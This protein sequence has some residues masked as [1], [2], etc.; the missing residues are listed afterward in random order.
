V[1]V[2]VEGDQIPASSPVDQPI[3]L[4]HSPAVATIVIA[5]FESELLVIAAG[6]RDHGQCL[7]IDARAGVVPWNG[8]GIGLQHINPA[9]QPIRQHLFEFGEGAQ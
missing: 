7:G 6:G 2:D 3:R 1:S 4:D 9:P 5:V 8:D